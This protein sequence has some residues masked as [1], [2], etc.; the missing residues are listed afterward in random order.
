MCTYLHE[1][2]HSQLFTQR[3]FLSCVHVMYV[4]L[5]H[6]CSLRQSS[7]LCKNTMVPV[8]TVVVVEYGL[9]PDVVAIR[10]NA[11]S[12]LVRISVHQNKTPLAHA[13]GTTRLGAGCVVRACFQAD[14]QSSSP[15]L[16]SHQ[17]CPG[18]FVPHILTHT[19]SRQTYAF[20]SI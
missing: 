11:W 16:P 4:A 1:W 12:C 10:N 20:S 7:T 3:Y 9:F 17:P 14:L 6:S 19:W 18:G 5:V 8:F 13:R 2:N 15:D